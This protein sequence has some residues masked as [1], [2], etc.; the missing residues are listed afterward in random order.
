MSTCIDFTPETTFLVFRM[1]M[2]D[3]LFLADEILQR[4][5]HYIQTLCEDISETGRYKN[6][7]K[8]IQLIKVRRS[9]ILHG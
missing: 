5:L 4:C 1:V 9:I 8:A 3:K 2:Y 6:E 7:D